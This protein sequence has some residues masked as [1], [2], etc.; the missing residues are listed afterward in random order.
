MRRTDLTA[1]LNFKLCYIARYLRRRMIIPLGNFDDPE[2]EGGIN[3]KRKW[4]KRSKVSLEKICA[5]VLA[6]G[7]LFVC[8]CPGIIVFGFVPTKQAD[9]SADE[10]LRMIRLWTTTIVTMNSSLNCLIFFYKN[11]ALRRVGMNLVS[12]SFCTKKLCHL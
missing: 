1:T 12:K 7:C 8:Y 5:C 9:M 11:I 4:K 6:V 10:T 3:V 2:T